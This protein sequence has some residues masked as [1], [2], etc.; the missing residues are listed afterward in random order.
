[1]TTPYEPPSGAADLAA[2]AEDAALPVVLADAVAEH[3]TATADA[4][5]DAVHYPHLI[6]R[7]GVQVW[8]R[9]PRPEALHAFSMAVSKHSKATIQTDMVT[10]FVRSH[11]CEQSY[12]LL[13]ERMMDPEGSFEVSDLG[14]VM[15]DIATLGTA[16]PIAP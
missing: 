15:Q 13:L 7:G 12:E 3:V 5:P 2:Q 4:G 14:M 6:T 16:R 10:L 11:I 9:R 1:M 8:A